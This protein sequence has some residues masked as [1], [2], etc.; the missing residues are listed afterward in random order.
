MKLTANCSGACALLLVLASTPAQAAPKCPPGMTATQ[1][2]KGCAAD[3]KGA[4]SPAGSFDVL[5]NIMDTTKKEINAKQE[6]ESSKNKLLNSEHTKKFKNGYWQH[7][8]ANSTAKLGE[9]CTA[10]FIRE[11][12]SVAIL[13]P[14]GQYRGALMM[15]MPVLENPDFPTSSQSRV[16]QI[17]LKQANDP[18]VTVGA[19]NFAIG[20]WEGPAIAFAVPS[21]EAALAGMEEKLDFHLAWEGKN[22]GEIEWHSG[23]AARDALKNCLA[24]KK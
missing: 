9:Y 5:G 16:L 10:M 7:F 21:I 12:M 14:G 22:I 1:D 11:G 23:I 19:F 8:Q 13:G 17:S 2:G 20:A 15:F 4:A 6:L 24:T 18:V 3:S